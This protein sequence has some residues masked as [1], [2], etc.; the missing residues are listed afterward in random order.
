MDRYYLQVY[1]GDGK[2]KS[3]AAAGLCLRALGRGKKIALIPFYKSAP[4]GEHLALERLGG[5]VERGEPPE[6]APWVKEAK[7]AWKEHSRDQFQ[8]GGQILQQGEIDL[9]VMDE[10]IHALQ[11]G[12]ISR[13]A[14]EDFIALAREKAE[15]VLT[16]RNAPEWLVEEADLVSEILDRKHYYE[17]GLAAREGIEF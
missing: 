10:M 7:A 16:G 12:D 6:A 4:S 11:K 9:L 1:T 2:G 15:L 3:T 5:R 14:A 8:R 17:R 13:E